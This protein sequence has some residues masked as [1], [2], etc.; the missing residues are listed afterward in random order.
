M[1]Q[2]VVRSLLQDALEGMGVQLPD[3]RL[4]RPRDPAHGDVATNVAMLLAGTLKKP[5][6][7]IAE[8]IARRIPTGSSGVDA[9]EVAGPMESAV[10]LAPWSF[11]SCSAA[12]RAGRSNGLSSLVS[13][14]RRATPWGALRTTDLMQTMML[15][16]MVL[17]IPE[18]MNAE[19]Y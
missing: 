1:T 16:D 11:F 6:R 9:V 13:T 8:E 19:V 18:L 4:E 7:E 14:V 17:R 15:R 2:D 5:P 12:S 3:I 10:T